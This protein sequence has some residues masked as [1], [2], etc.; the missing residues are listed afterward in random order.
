MLQTLLAQQ[1][2]SLNF[3][4]ENLDRIQSEK[5]L[6][7]MLNCVGSLVFS[8]VG[9]SGMI[10]EKIAA[11]YSSIGVRAFYVSPMDLVHGELGRISSQDVFICLS[12]SGE[13]KELLALIPYLKQKSVK[14]LGWISQEGSSL[15]KIVDLSVLLPVDAELCPFNLAPTISAEVQ[16]IFGDL[17]TVAFMH[18]QELSLQEYA[19]NHPAGSIGKIA[20]YKVEDVML[21]EGHLPVCY[22]KDKLKDVLVE[23]SRKRCGCLVVIDQDKKVQGVFTDGDLRRALQN[24]PAFILEEMMENLMTQKFLCIEEKESLYKAAK[25]M[26]IQPNQWI[27]MLPVVREGCLVGIVRLHDVVGVNLA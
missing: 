10:A 4:F 25:V 18:K 1:Q 5:I 6:Q 9:K 15:G 23:L 11:T 16:L 27:S 19:K 26:N 3:F 24:Q 17:L 2:N 21:T 20:N 8:G 22:P 14:I 12:K 13:T 7:V